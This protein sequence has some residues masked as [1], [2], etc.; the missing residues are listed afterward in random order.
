MILI[1]TQ[2]FDP[3]ANH[4]AQVLEARGAEFIRFNPADFPMRTSLSVGYAPNGKM[5]SF[6]RLEDKIIDL[7]QLQSVWSRRPQAPVPHDEIQNPSVREF[8]ARD[9]QTFVQDVWD[10][11]P[12]RWVPGHPVAIQRAQLCARQK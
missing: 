3:H 9:C 7:A 1:L 11:L 5:R 12:C 4:V 6:L 10:T 8:I 2:P